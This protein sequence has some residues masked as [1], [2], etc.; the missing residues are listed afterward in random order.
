[1][2]TRRIFISGLALD[3]RIGI[4]EHERRATQPLHID[5]EFDIDITRSVDDH[6][7]QS[8]LDYRSL[9]EAIVHECTQAHVN[10]IETLSEQVAARLLA[11]FP[12]VRTLR[13]RISKPMAFSDCNAV[14]VEIQIS[15]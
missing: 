9:R 1:M 4:L 7:I 6:D 5:A 3:A 15:R 10:L 12:E 14:G 8:V 2:P 11:E 13:L